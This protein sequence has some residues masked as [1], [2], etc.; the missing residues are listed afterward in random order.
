[1][2]DSESVSGETFRQK[3]WETYHIL[4]LVLY[5]KFLE[6]ID[7]LSGQKTERAIAHMIVLKSPFFYKRYAKGGW[8][9]PQVFP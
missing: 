3:D 5:D 2:K 1:M 8:F 6:I 9:H 7:M 4:N